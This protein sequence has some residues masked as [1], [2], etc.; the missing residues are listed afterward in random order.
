LNFFVLFRLKTNYL[1]ATHCEER[2][3]GPN[4]KKVRYQQRNTVYFIKLY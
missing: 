2:T 4:S 3:I 1:L